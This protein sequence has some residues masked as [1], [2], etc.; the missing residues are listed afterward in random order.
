MRY[1]F[2]LL[3]AAC[4][5]FDPTGIPEAPPA[6]YRQWY[7]ETEACSGLTGDFD[8]IQWQHEYDIRNGDI[9]YGGY[10]VHPHTIIIRDDFALVAWKV[11]HEMMHELLQHSGHPALYFEQVCGNLMGQ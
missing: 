7:A 1:L 4:G 5:S 11:K 8:R 3:L 2:V 10:W 6:I 9:T